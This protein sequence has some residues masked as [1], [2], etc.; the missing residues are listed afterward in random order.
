VEIACI[1]YISVYTQDMKDKK[2]ST[3]IRLE[4]SL[5]KKA[6]SIG[7]GNLTDGIRKALNKYKIK[8]GKQHG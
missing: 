8:K 1:V 5:R 3:L 7:E 6:A 4:E 2:V